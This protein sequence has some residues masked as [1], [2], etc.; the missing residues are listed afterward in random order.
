MAK[1]S[2][3]E[4]ATF[5]GEWFLAS[6]K[7]IPGTLSWSPQRA[8]LDLHDSFNPLSGEIFGDETQSYPSIFGTTTDSQLITLLDA[9]K[10]G[11]SFSFGQAGMRQRDRLIS[12]WL[13]VGAHVET[14][15]LYSEIRA[16]I[17][18]LQ[19]WIGR[20][21]VEQ[22]VVRTG[23]KSTSILYRVDALEE[24]R[25]E[26]HSLPAT[27]GWGIDR[28]FSGNL[29]SQIVVN[30][31]GHVRIQPQRPQN[32]EWFFDQLGRLTTLLAFLSGSPMGTDQ[33]SA[34]IADVGIEVEVLVALR[35][36]KYCKHQQPHEFFMLRNGME[37]DLGN[38]FSK[39]FE[40]YDTIAMP[41]QLALSVLSSED[42][43]LHVEFL[44]L[45]QALE[46][47][48]R[49]TMEGLYSSE[50][51]YEEVKRA[52]IS[53]IPST[54]GF[55][56]RDSLKSRIKYGNEIALRKRLD[57]L[58]GRLELPL[59]KHILGGD[60]TVPRSWIHTRNYYTHWDEA[61]R[62]QALDGLE[63]HRA[64]GRMRH[65]LRVLYL[66]LVG[67]PQSAIAKSLV[68]ACRESQYLI[69]LNNAD[70]RKEHP[71]AEHKPLMSISVK[72]A[73]DPEGAA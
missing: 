33:I 21:G 9:A 16:R 69:Q 19:M 68:N 53:A 7:K 57:T 59:R 73:S 35:E 17:P 45:M 54:V 11:G 58:V 1:Y 34:K 13:I 28:Q 72:D 15:A 22:S 40:L 47:F 65:L 23:D 14:Q 67:V 43:W 52:L 70:Y 30:T 6:S 50:A 60:G 55:D 71:E 27:L 61:S 31:S 51:A 10:A 4:N 38:I 37:A 12:S 24:E 46:G 20:V 32:L 8:S 44:S 62:K 64:G 2:I 41:S 49:A 18:G 39:W 48:H 66:D 29:V 36:A 63:M 25:T 56:Q 3:P 5:T 42:L 26:I